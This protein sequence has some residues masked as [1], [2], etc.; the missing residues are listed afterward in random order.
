MVP[1]LKQILET[2]VHAVRKYQAKNL[3]ILYDAIGTL[4]D[5]VGSHLNRPDYIELLM[6]PLIE[7]W[8]VLRNDDK[9]LFPLLECL[10][11]IAT[12]LQTGFLPYCEPVFG[13]CI[14][15]VQ[16]T[17][18]ANGPDTT[19]DKDFM[20]VA[21]DLLSGL[22]E[23]L[24]NIFS[25]GL[26]L[27]NILFF[28]GSNIDP[29][30]ERSNLLPLLERCAQDPMAEVRQ[31]SFALLGDLTKACFRHVRKHLNFFLPLLTQN[32]DPHHVSVCNNAIWAIGEIAV[33]IGSEIQPFVSVIL[34]S[35]IL[36][37]NRNN[38]P[39]TLLENTAITI[40]RL[41]LVCPNDVSTQLARFIRPWCIALRNIRDNEEKDSAFRG[42]CNMIIL[43]PLGVTNEF[44]YVCD[45]IAS[46]EKPPM[47]LHA[48]FRDI[49][50]TFK[51][52]F[53]NEQWKQLTDRFPLPLRQRLQ[54]HYGV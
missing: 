17:L 30:I 47:E 42:I 7:R 38:T 10:S 6:P 39:K 1:Y 18:E 37:I 35:L 32:L 25:F 14:S 36:I 15:L 43:N 41:G 4:A 26:I 21:L 27:I 8:N 13:R 22:S 3:L 29:L 53:G 52:E 2:L 11:S 45:A 31:S 24:G 54:I 19:S 23:G 44:I 34:E 20:I 46:W 51:Q 33:Q 12:A 28:I 40:G 48:K 5:S 50:Q 9:D 49:L 16:Q